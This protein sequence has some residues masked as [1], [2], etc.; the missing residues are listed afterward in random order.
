MRA[1][2]AC[3]IHP[4]IDT[5]FEFEDVSAAYRRLESQ[6]HFGKIVIRVTKN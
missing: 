1:I 2:A 5:V 3:R 6:Q 4:V